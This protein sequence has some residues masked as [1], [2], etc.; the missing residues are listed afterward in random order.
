MK[1]TLLWIIVAVLAI[2]SAACDVQS[3]MLFPKWNSISDF[4]LPSGKVT[5]YTKLSDEMLTFNTDMSLGDLFTF[6]RDLFTKEGYTERTKVTYANKTGFGLVFDGHPSG[7][8]I[9]VQG[10]EA[11]EGG[12]STVTIRFRDIDNESK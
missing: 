2:S 12:L 10:A 11:D 4:P 9:I 6:Y 3:I 8:E 5:D 7:K 1:A